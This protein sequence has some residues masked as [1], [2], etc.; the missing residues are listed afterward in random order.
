MATFVHSE[1]STTTPIW[2]RVK[3]EAPFSDEYTLI[4]LGHDFKTSNFATPVYFSYRMKNRT[5]L[6]FSEDGVYVF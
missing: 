1:R 4:P 3:Q 6:L 5:A 2:S